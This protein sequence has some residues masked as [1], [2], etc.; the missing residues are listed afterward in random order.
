MLSTIKTIQANHATHTSVIINITW[1]EAQP[2]WRT[3][4]SHQWEVT[5]RYLYAVEVPSNMVQLI[6]M[7]ALCECVDSV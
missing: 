7:T 4:I 3:H 5:D 2:T 1:Y 6:S